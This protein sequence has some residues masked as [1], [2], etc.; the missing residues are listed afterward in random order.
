MNKE[1]EKKQVVI[2]EGE[3]FDV[4]I[5]HN[6]DDSNA[7]VNM[8]MFGLVATSDIICTGEESPMGVYIK[9]IDYALAFG[10][11]RWGEAFTNAVEAHKLGV[12]V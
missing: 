2:R 11:N 10:S 5:S 7:L 6:I 1:P 3:N 12:E 8:Q 9:L 4:T